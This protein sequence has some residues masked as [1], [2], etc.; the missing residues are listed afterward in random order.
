MSKQIKNPQDHFPG[1]SENP[2][3]GVSRPY[4]MY[5]SQ[6]GLIDE[7]QHWWQ[8]RHVGGAP[9][10]M[11]QFPAN[12]PMIPGNPGNAYSFPCPVI[13]HRVEGID[14]HR[15]MTGTASQSDMDKW[16]AGAKYLEEQGVRA[17]GANCG[18]L[19]N[20]IEAV[21]K[22]VSVPYYPSAVLQ[23]PL[24][25]NLFPKSAKVMVITYADKQDMIDF[26]TLGGAGVREED[27]ER[28]VVTGGK[29]S[30]QWAR[31][32]SL[33]GEF[34]AHLWQ[35]EVVEIAVSSIRENPDIAAIVQ[36]CTE[37]PP[38]SWAVQRATGLPVFDTLT[39]MKHMISAVTQTPYH[40]HI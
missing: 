39:G 11:L 10:G 4:P 5:V 31:S 18:F 36:E 15:M 34:N 19:T 3:K 13:F 37:L 14:I 27:Y 6:T 9:F 24:L 23:I 1:V 20:T 2:R 35:E 38:F 32:A 29:T 30:T 22:A 40:G 8:E 12:I 26:G 17:I 28:L 21:N 25:L 7:D 33:A 16:I